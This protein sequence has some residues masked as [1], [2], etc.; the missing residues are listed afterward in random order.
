MTSKQT[1]VAGEPVPMRA[2]LAGARRKEPELLKLI[3][4]LVRAESPSDVKGAVDA[5]GAVVQEHAH[6]LGGRTKVHRQRAFGDVLELRFGPRRKSRD[7]GP[8]WLACWG[9]G[10]ALGHRLAGSTGIGRC[11]LFFAA[12]G[13]GQVRLFRRIQDLQL[14]LVLLRLGLLLVTA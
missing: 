1:K 8:G 10:L 14:A 6:K 3:Q 12:R 11:R 2:L 9:T 7:L 4:R 5:C 13:A